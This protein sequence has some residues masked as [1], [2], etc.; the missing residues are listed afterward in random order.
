MALPTA[1]AIM[2]PTTAAI[3]PAIIGALEAIAIPID[4]GTA[5]RKTTIDAGRSYLATVVRRSR[6]LRGRSS[7][8]SASATAAEAEAGMAWSLSVSSRIL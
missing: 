4:N 6:R 2:P 8:A 7:A 5:T 1:P 3:S